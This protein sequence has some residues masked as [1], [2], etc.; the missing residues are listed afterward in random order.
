MGPGAEAESP[1]QPTN[2]ELCGASIRG[3]DPDNQGGKK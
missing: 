2:F 1:A 3:V